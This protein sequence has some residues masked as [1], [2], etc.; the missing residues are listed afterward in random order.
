MRC[1]GSLAAFWCVLVAATLASD[2]AHALTIELTDVAS[3]RVERQRAYSARDLPLPGTPDLTTLDQRL[4]DRGVEKGDPV[5]IRVFKA[6]SL[7][8][9][10]VQKG[11]RF[12]L[13]DTYPICHWSGTLGPKLK[14]G[15]RQNP[16]GFYSF[17]RRLLHRSGKHPRSLNLGFPNS[18]DRAMERTGSYILVHGGC[19]SVGCFAMTD[20][21]MDEIYQLAHAALR[22]GQDRVHVHVFPFRMTEV[23][24]AAH[25]T[26]P[27][28]P[29]WSNLKVGYDAFEATHVPPRVGVCDRRYVI[30]MAMPGEAGD[31]GP[32]APCGAVSAAAELNLPSRADLSPSLSRFATS[33]SPSAVLVRAAAPARARA[34][35]VQATCNPNL[36]SCRLFIA[37]KQ[38]AAAMAETSRSKVASRSVTARSR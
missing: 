8:E 26:S 20:P 16:E 23:N 32:L 10:W 9:M 25:S 1:L 2:R 15:D 27:W 18:F 28:A 3:D 17:D 31:Q 13:L 35:K 29:F 33:E 22:A 12:V 36:S 14:E 24:L 37:N 6:E 19:S 5:F 21:V 7:L 11:E 30:E 38:R 4:A 34:P